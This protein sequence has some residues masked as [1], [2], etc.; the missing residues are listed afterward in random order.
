MT[1]EQWKNFLPRL[2]EAVPTV[3]QWVTDLQTRHEPA[4]LHPRDFGNPALDEYFGSELLANTRVV[5]V[6]ELPFPPVTAHGLPEFEEMAR[7]DMAAITFG[8]MYFVRPELSTEEFHFHELVHVVQWATLGM[9]EFL[10]TYAVG[11]VQDGYQGSPLE[12]IAYGLQ[13]QFLA[14]TA[15][16]PVLDLVASHAIR[17]RNEARSLFQSCGIDW[18]T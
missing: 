13:D 1:R 9:P 7:M 14:R 2:R 12:A 3:C 17:A 11:I 6:D 8:N 4:S 10:K 5:F 18:K 16:V 15:P